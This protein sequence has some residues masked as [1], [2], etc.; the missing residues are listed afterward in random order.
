LNVQELEAQRPAPDGIEPAQGLRDLRSTLDALLGSSITRAQPAPTAATTAATLLRRRLAVRGWVAPAALRGDIG[1]ADW[2]AALRVVGQEVELAERIRPGQWFMALAARKRVFGAASLDELRAASDEVHPDDGKDYVRLA[3]RVALASAGDPARYLGESGQLQ[4]Q[5]AELL[6]ELSRMAAWGSSI[7]LLTELAA[8]AGAQLGRHRRDRELEAVDPATVFGRDRELQMIRA[9]LRRPL[10]NT[11]LVPALYV[12]GIGGSGKSTLLMAAQ[13][14]LRLAGSDIVVRLDFDNA[15]MDPLSQEQMDILFLRALAVEEPAMAPRLQNVIAQLQDLSDSRVRARLETEGDEFTTTAKSSKLRKE[16]M[17]RARYATKSGS[18]AE[19]AGLSERSERISALQAVGEDPDFRQRSVVLFLDTVENVL[20]LGPDAVDSV[21]E[22]LGSLPLAVPRRDLRVVLAGRD[23][24]GSSSITALVDRFRDYGLRLADKLEIG[25]LDSE[26]A[27]AMLVQRGLPPPDAKLAAQ[28]LPRNPL[29]LRL[30]AKAWETAKED[31]TSIQDAYRDGRIDR[32]TASSYLAQR[33]IQHVP[34][35]PARRYAVAAMALERV[36]EKD[37]RDIVIP[38]VDGGESGDRKL[39]RR[40]YEGLLRTTWLADEEKVGTLRWHTELRALALPM[41]QADPDHARVD[42]LVRSAVEV[43]AHKSSTPQRILDLASKLL[44]PTA[45]KIQ[46]ATGIPVAD[47]VRTELRQ[48]EDDL[49]RIQLEGVGGA[50]GEGDRLVAQGRGAR[51]LELYRERPT[52]D[53]GVPPTFVIRGLAQTGD[54]AN[55]DVD[56]E[57]IVREL[58]QHFEARG[59]NIQRPAVERLYWLTRLEML[60][61]PALER[62][63][64]DLLRDTCRTLAFKPRDGALFGLIGV[65]EALTAKNGMRLIAPAT[66]PPPNA[67]LGAEPRFSMVRTVYDRL[68]QPDKR[69]LWVKTT[70]GATLALRQRWFDEIEAL[71]LEECVNVAG[72]R[73]AMPQL[74]S[75]VQELRVLPLVQVEQFISSC[76]DI[77]VQFDLSRVSPPEAALALR[78]SFVEFH[79][80][81]AALLSGDG[82]RQSLA[83]LLDFVARLPMG[84]SVLALGEFDYEKRRGAHERDMRAAFTAIIVALERARLLGDFCRQLQRDPSSAFGQPRAASARR[85]VELAGRY[86]AWEQALDPFQH[87]PSNRRSPA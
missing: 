23:A 30:A 27:R 41:I 62:A 36:T 74:W 80:P 40:I 56:A 44:Y 70:L 82:Y 59:G 83:G 39:A 15:Y 28:A 5:P 1:D 68:P 12:S 69:G 51:A 20:R 72:G 24:L 46:R 47:A 61:T 78:G 58:R 26:S 35:E 9:F 57:A 34:G 6:Q 13:K 11:R 86:V 77:R 85:A 49:H 84:D 10:D 16:R 3:L 65:A 45:S 63:H 29:V 64:V 25:D 75:Q 21:L 4:D 48:A 17:R 14:E 8:T 81:L 37:L 43:R 50:V 55:E 66:W 31:V 73:G 79:A 38:I 60:R 2:D 87:D 67:D 53:R 33:V 54:W 42:L 32:Q 19:A 76:R 7:P 71:S 52:R 18:S 22:W